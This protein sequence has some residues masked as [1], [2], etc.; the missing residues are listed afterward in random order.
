MPWK[1]FA[2]HSTLSATNGST[3]VFMNAQGLEIQAILDSRE[4]FKN[5]AQ[6]QAFADALSKTEELKK[7]FQSTRQL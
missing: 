1:I 6:F 5:L 2:L 3:F 7:S 4:T